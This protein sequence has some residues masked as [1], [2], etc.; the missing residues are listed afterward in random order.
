MSVL[1]LE[2]FI[3]SENFNKYQ[4]NIKKI[5][6]EI[7]S[8][9]NEEKFDFL[10][11]VRKDNAI[12]LVPKT[13]NKKNI[14]T[15]MIYKKHIRFLIL[16]EYDKNIKEISEIDN[17][18]INAFKNKYNRLTEDKIQMSIY[19]DSGIVDELNKE[20]QKSGKKIHDIIV[21]TLNEKIYE[22]NYFLNLN[23]KEEFSI[24]IQNLGL[25][26]EEKY[27]HGLE[28]KIRKRVAFFYVISAYQEDYME[29]QNV[30]F[31]VNPE[32]KEMLGPRDIIE[33]WDEELYNPSCSMYGLIKSIIDK[34]KI[35]ILEF[36][37]EYFDDNMMFLLENAMKILTGS[38]TIKKDEVVEVVMCKNK[39]FAFEI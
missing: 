8:R 19:L 38:L 18:L 30:K 6:K 3:E 33:N 32:S 23:H 1:I 14:C 7:L 5:V 15:L 25:Y 24:L 31:T 13:N 39:G 28:E 20:S 16:N 2:K 34:E 37:Q 10:I 21:E 11:K 4:E 29:Y 27:I 36:F 35:N 17:S 12:A 9:I 26:A 22:K